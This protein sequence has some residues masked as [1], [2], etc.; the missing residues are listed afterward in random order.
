MSDRLYLIMDGTEYPAQYQ[1][2]FMDKDCVAFYDSDG[3]KVLENSREVLEANDGFVISKYDLN[4]DFILDSGYEVINEDLAATGYKVWAVGESLGQTLKE[5]GYMLEKEDTCV[6][7]LEDMIVENGYLLRT[8]WLLIDRSYLRTPSI[9]L[10]EG[11][12]TIKVTGI[13]LDRS[14]YSV[15]STSLDRKRQLF[16]EGT[17]E[18]LKY[19]LEYLEQEISADTLILGVDVHCGARDF[20]VYIKNSEGPYVRV[21]SIEVIKN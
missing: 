10:P 16:E 4:L 21:K 6:Y 18:Y 15:E 12:Y 2:A 14:A 13:D 19:S 9:Y 3:S 8:S 7:T 5:E 1:W 20:Q 11:S 17:E